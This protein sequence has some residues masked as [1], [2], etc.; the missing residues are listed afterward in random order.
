MEVEETQSFL[1]K[2]IVE[3]TLN[4]LTQI[5]HSF[6]VLYNSFFT[7]TNKDLVVLKCFISKNLNTNIT[8]FIPV[9]GSKLEEG[10]CRKKPVFYSKVKSGN[11]QVKDNIKKEIVVESI[12]APIRYKN[13]VIGHLIYTAVNNDKSDILN[14]FIESLIFNIEKELE[15][16]ILKRE[17]I[18]FMDLI[19]IK[20]NKEV[21][22][23]FSMQE[24][25]ILKY[26]L[27]SYSNIEIANALYISESTV[28]TYLRRIYEKCGTSNRIDTTVTILCNHILNK[29][30]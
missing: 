3:I 15:K 30:Y 2:K 11:I 24:Q 14:L 18:I 16:S 1:E 27:M 26:M 19:K 20:E 4:Y 8:D 21:E 9:V 17:L 13:V 6:L 10:Y 22:K 7:I 28:K 29:L 5:K 12:T 25:M 23:C